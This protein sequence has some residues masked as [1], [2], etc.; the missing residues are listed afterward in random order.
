MERVARNLLRRYGRII[1]AVDR[2]TG[3]PF[4]VS[5]DKDFS[6]LY[7]LVNE[8]TMTGWERC[9]A[10]Y[11]AVNY[12]CSCGIEGDIVECGVWRGG[13]CMLMASQLKN[14]GQTERDIYLYDTYRG[15]S[16]PTTVDIGFD[17]MDAIKVHKN[18]QR[19]GYNKWAIAT[20]PDVRA[21]MQSVGYNSEKL[22]FVEGLVEDSIPRTRPEQIAILRLDTDW[23]ESTYHEMQ[24]L[25]PLLAPGGVLIV[26]DYGDW[27]GARKAVDQ[28]L[29][30]N[31]IRILLNRVAGAAIGVKSMG[32]R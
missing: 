2:A 6:R 5:T 32:E 25:Y 1:Q 15:M 16:E 14:L 30:E 23:F 12:I 8:F 17:G 4:D 21:N 10:A 29:S 18:L 13:T 24:H 19:A 7:S 27:H 28:Y 3:L 31:G 22:H 20:L 9:Y 11:R 26:D